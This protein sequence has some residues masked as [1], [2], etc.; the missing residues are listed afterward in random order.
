MTSYSAV[1]SGAIAAGYDFR[2]FN[3]IVDVGGDHGALLRTVLD[4]APKARGIV[5]DLPDVVKGVTDTLGG[6]IEC[7]GS[8]FFERVPSGGDCY[9]LKHIIHDWGDEHC[10]KLLGNV[11]AAMKPDGKVLVC[12]MVMPETSGP[13]PAKFNDLNML[14]MTEGGCERTE[15][16]FADLF[17]SSGLRLTRVVPTPTPVSVVEAAKA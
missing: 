5:V 13:H 4:R 10:R 1:T 16:E 14:A 3:C 12:D 7:I 8:D 6:R 9:I 15:T 11:G 2:S 17:E